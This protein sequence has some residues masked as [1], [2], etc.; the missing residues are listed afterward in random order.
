MR[1]I[2]LKRRARIRAASF[3]FSERDWRRLLSRYRNACAYCGERPS[4]LQREHVIPLAR[5]GTHGVGNIVPACAGCNYSKK[6]KFV[7][8][9]RRPLFVPAR[10]GWLP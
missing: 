1:A 9:W 5:G 6:D 2:R 8:E 4:E 10:R 3:E 7:V